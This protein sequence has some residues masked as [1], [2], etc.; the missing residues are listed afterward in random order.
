MQTPQPR[1]RHSGGVH[2]SCGNQITRRIR[3][4][5]TRSTPRKRE[6]NSSA[7]VP[8]QRPTPRKPL[9]D[10]WFPQPR[11]LFFFRPRFQSVARALIQHRPRASGALRAT[12][13]LRASGPLPT[14]GPLTAKSPR[15]SPAPG[16]LWACRR[17]T[18]PRSRCLPNRRPRSPSTARSGLSGKA[19][20]GIANH[21]PTF[22]TSHRRSGS[23]CAG[24]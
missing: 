19:G 4:F 9:S 2:V 20:W 16:S 17:L 12:G 6:P 24:K 21:E 22:R 8:P 14:T 1:I 5:G 15:A 13:A 23:S 7:A 10:P 3:D 11:V 18:K